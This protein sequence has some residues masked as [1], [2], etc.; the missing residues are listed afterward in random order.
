MSGYKNSKIQWRNNFIIA[1]KKTDK[2]SE[3]KDKNNI[4]NTKT[5]EETNCKI[6]PSINKTE[7]N[8]NKNACPKKTNDF[9]EGNKNTDIPQKTNTDNNILNNEPDCFQAT[10]QK[11]K[12]KFA[13]FDNYKFITE[14]EIINLKPKNTQ[15]T[16][17]LNN[18]TQMKNLKSL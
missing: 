2:T 13:E 1:D 14:E 16:F 5:N 10:A 17:M 8:E 12:P 6:S 7:Q 9:S 4:E 15:L 3:N 18:N 11:T